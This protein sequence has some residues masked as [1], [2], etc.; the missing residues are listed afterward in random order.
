MKAVVL[1]L[2]ALLGDPGARVRVRLDAAKK[3]YDAQEYVAAID[4]LRQVPRD[5]AATRAQRAQALEYLGL[6]YL[7]L[8]KRQRAREAFEDLLSIDS[9]YTLRDPSN[10]PKLRQF[11]EEVKAAFVPGYKPAMPAQMEHAAPLGAVAGHHVEFDAQVTDGAK[12]VADV[13]V[14]WRQ[15]GLLEYRH[16]GLA[17]AEAH[18]RGFVTPPHETVP[19][20]LEYY[21]E[22]RDVA[23]RV[24][25]RIGGP[26]EPLS[27]DVAGAPLPPPPW[28]KRWWFWTA[29]G[30]AVAAGTVAGVLITTERHAQPGSLGQVQLQLRF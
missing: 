23:G 27:I 26:E 21:L 5:P 8:G 7:I 16:D 10:S 2:V 3:L 12:N 22:A 18:Y 1:L 20:V 30:S 25:S 9:N 19:Y 15:R 17:R 11:F 13:T 4:M 6:S 24:I 14:W 28:Y 29:A